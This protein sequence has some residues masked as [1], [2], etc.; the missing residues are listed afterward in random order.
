MQGSSGYAHFKVQFATCGRG[1]I[2]LTHP[3][4]R[5][6]SVAVAAVYEGGA[7]AGDDHW[8]HPFHPMPAAVAEDVAVYF[9]LFVSLFVLYTVVVVE[10]VFV[11]V[12]TQLY[13]HVPAAA[14][15]SVES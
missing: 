12:E 3:A 7:V 8:L 10:V 9:A 4:V 2:A 14:S 11:A 13:V 15:C 1:I 5:C 6:I